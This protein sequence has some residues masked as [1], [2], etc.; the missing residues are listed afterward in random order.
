MATEQ[1]T[2]QSGSSG[3]SGTAVRYRAENAGDWGAPV[4]T[5]G[6]QYGTDTFAL[7]DGARLFFRFWQAADATA[8]VLVFL[9]GLGAH[10]GWFIDMGNELHARG[11]TV[12]M[13][14]HR[15]FG[16]SDGDRGHIRDWHLYPADTSAFLD[17][18][19]RRAPG[20]PLF[21]LGHSMGG[22]F[23]LYVA[24]ADAHEGRNRLAGL[25]L[26]NPWV[27]EVNRIP[28]RQQL[29]IGLRGV[30]GSSR[31]VDY[32]YPL[33]VLTANP[34]AHQLLQ[35][36]PNWVKRQTASFLYQVGLRMAGGLLKQAR[37]VR[38]PALVLQ[39]EADTSVLIK[40]GR[41]M[42]DVLGSKDKA[43]KLYPGFA[44]DFEFEPERSALDE[45]IARW[46]VAHA[47]P[48]QARA[49]G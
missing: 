18:V 46:C 44:H 4:A 47:Q 15:G 14:D 13:P 40:R 1:T 49:Q 32:E 3:S 39:S 9:H 19:G 28:A 45:D 16:R 35:S 41:K 10:T 29:G 12:Y 23:A 34:E 7:P 36:D 22:R 21:L 26:I 38:C 37:T 42:Y 30:R 48:P 31:I 2:G 25:V 11:L 43:Y 27:K 8:P 20:A 6:G 24:A 17:E 5:D 33:S